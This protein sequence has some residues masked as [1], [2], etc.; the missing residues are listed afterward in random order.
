GI[1]DDIGKAVGGAVN[2]AVKVTTAPTSV[3]INTARAATGNA[4]PAAIYQPYVDVAH[5]AGN[6]I[7]STTTVIAAPKEEIY[8]R[9]QSLAEQAGPGAE[10]VF[11]LGT[12]ANRYSDQLASSGSYAAANG[13]RLQN[14]LQVLAVPLAAAVRSARERYDHAA[15]PLPS[16]VRAGLQGK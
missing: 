16:D 15:K 4:P 6:T 3:V 8:R 2:T 5:S 7:Q 1:F 10:F 12:Y 13:L 9:V 11:D 14:P